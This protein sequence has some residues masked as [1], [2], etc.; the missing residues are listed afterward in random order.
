MYLISFV[1]FC[2]CT[3]T[4]FAIL[5]RCIPL[6]RSSVLSYGKLQSIAVHPT[7]TIASQ[8]AQWTVPKSWFSHFY[9]VGLISALYCFAEIV[10]LLQW[11]G[12]GP[13]LY[14]LRVW[15]IPQASSHIS[16]LESLVALA[17]LTLHLARRVYESFYIERSSLEARM[18]VSH[19][20]AGVGFYG[21][22]VL[23]TWLEGAANF[24]VWSGIPSPSALGLSDLLC[25]RVVMATLL[26]FYASMHQ[27][28]CHCI[29]A[30]LRTKKE[31][32]HYQIPRGDWFEWIVVPH[33]FADILV[34]LSL[35]ILHGFRNWILVCG[36]IWT[37]INLS[38][39]ASGTEE[40]YKTK[41]G[42]R[43]QATFPKGRWIIL[44]GI[45]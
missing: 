24:G 37:V 38:I 18:H 43:Y 21:A 5:A 14:C 33:Y 10:L 7:S 42:L 32:N 6:L 44:P 27:H 4:F 22:M 11:H 13:V 25:T 45:Y 31:E 41:F 35:C 26:F 29:L 3:L 19:Y 15:D 9:V 39:T 1:C 2:L 40:W 20:L 17:L 34:Y 8:L 30:S 23:A 12:H 28:Q 36:L 16:V